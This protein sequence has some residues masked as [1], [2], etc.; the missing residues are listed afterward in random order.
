MYLAFLS[1]SCDEVLHHLHTSHNAPY[2]TPLFI[3]GDSFDLRWLDIVF[4]GQY[5]PSY[6]LHRHKKRSGKIATTVVL[7]KGE[8]CYDRG[9]NDIVVVIVTK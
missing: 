1:F 6:K 5:L 7:D 9:C 2:L 8:I 4:Q 3:Q